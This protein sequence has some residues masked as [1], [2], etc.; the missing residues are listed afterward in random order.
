MKQLSVLFLDQVLSVVQVN[1]CQWN[2]ITGRVSGSCCFRHQKLCIHPVLYSACNLQY[3]SVANPH[4]K[5]FLSAFTVTVHQ[6]RMGVS[7]SVTALKLYLPVVPLLKRGL[8]VFKVDWECVFTTQTKD[9]FLSSHITSCV[10]LS[11][12]PSLSSFSFQDKC[13]Q[14]FQTL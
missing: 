5:L 1:H 10:L 2:M 8:G 9:F 12:P 3:Q 6:T 13:W 14:R 4:R 11:F 7:V